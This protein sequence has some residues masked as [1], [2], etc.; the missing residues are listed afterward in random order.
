[1]AAIAPEKLQARVAA[2]A[3]IY[4]GSLIGLEQPLTGRP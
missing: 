1:V 2:N 3:D 4:S